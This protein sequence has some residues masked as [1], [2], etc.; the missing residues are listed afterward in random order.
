MEKVNLFISY[1]HADKKYV[2]EFYK[3]VNETDCPQINIWKDDKIL[4]GQE[5]D[6]EIE[7]SLNCAD[8]VLLIVSQDFLKSPYIS[9]NELSVALNRHEEG[10][11][12]VIPIFLRY[13]NL[14]SYPQITKLQGYPGTK[15]VL[16]DS[17]F[18]FKKDRYYTEIQEK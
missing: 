11:S 8:I 6:N 18:E 17:E 15:T 12:T 2:D 3:F 16:L 10:K 9:R 1:A 7:N 14:Q 4:L 5:W 13:C